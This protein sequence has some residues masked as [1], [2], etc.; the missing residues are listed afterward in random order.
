M[1][2]GLFEDKEHLVRV[3]GLFI[4]GVVLF[5]VIQG[6]FVPEGFGLY[7]H[8]RAGALEDNSKR[9][10]RF[11][12]HAACMDCHSDVAETKTH[13]KH[14]GVGCEACHWA[15]G[16]HAANPDSLVPE[17]PNGR[18][19]CLTCHTAESGRPSWFPQIDPAAHGDEGPCIACHQPHN[20]GAAPEAAQ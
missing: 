18:S 10:P 17:R 3:L 14:A 2:R 5:L 9:V 20:P 7:G 1:K 16:A 12:G 4:G 11:A 19:L 6:F 13:G 8:F 15:L